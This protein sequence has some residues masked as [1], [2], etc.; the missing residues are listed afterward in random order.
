MHRT[1]EWPLPE[2]ATFSAE[3]AVQRNRHGNVLRLPFL[4]PSLPVGEPP[5]QELFLARAE[6]HLLRTFKRILDIVASLLGLGIFALVLP[7]IGLMI[8]LDS[9]GP[10]FYVQN[11]VGIN[12][13]RRRQG[14][15]DQLDR[16]KVLRPGRPFK[17]W[18]LRTMRA[19]AEMNGPQWA[20]KGDTRVTRVGR[21]LR[22]TRLDEVPQFINV[23]RGDMSLIG[24][25]PERLCFIHKLEK[26]VPHY[27]DRLLVLPGITGLAQVV[28]GYD[29]S[30]ESVLRKVDLD[31][32]YIRSCSLLMDLRIIL[33]TIKVVLT[34]E[35]AN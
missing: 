6:S 26:Q 28:N 31:R 23:L 7:I 21:V 9:P 32:Q 5:A 20:A 24:P 34:G 8:K 19:D 22:R 4:A 10:V 30:L 2:F 27:R 13:R 12:R 15:R 35:G 3:R 33:K 17:I 29:D 11:R 16:R 1:K 14:A 25:R 18:K